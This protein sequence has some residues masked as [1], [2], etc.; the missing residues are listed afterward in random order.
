MNKWQVQIMKNRVYYTIGYYT[1]EKRAA[2]AY[3]LAAE[4]L[5]G[6]FAYRNMST[7]PR[8][9]MRRELLSEIDLALLSM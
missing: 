5:H 1:D 2:F 3:D 6:K 7:K 4:R 8:D 9:E